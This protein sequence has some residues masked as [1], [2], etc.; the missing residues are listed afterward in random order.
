MHGCKHTGVCVNVNTKAT[1]RLTEQRDRQ[2]I[3]LHVKLLTVDVESWSLLYLGPIARHRLSYGP[4][5]GRVIARSSGAE[6][7]EGCDLPRVPW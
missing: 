2:S 1:E 6:L 4:M 7:S 5:D 3:H